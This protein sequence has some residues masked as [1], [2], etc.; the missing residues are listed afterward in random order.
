MAAMAAL[1]RRLRALGCGVRRVQVPAPGRVWGSGG[2]L[3][4]IWGARVMAGAGGSRE[5]TICGVRGEL[6]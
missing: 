6:E 3:G 5:G 4:G 1:G 2:S